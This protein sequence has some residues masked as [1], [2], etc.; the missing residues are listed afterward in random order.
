MT[1]VDPREGC[2][3]DHTTSYKP[4]AKDT[5]LARQIQSMIISSSFVTL[6]EEEMRCRLQC[7]SSSLA[8]ICNRLDA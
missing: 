6:A 1:G 8:N 7:D 2:V 4:G 5:I 3:V